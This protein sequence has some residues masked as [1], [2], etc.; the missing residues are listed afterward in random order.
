MKMENPV[1]ERFPKWQVEIG[2]LYPSDPNFREMCD[3]YH[4]VV[5]AL[6]HWQA[7]ATG[8]APEEHACTSPAAQNN[9]A[10]IA[11]EYRVCLQELDDEIRTYLEDRLG[12]Y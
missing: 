5:L 8:Q 4:I 12:P 1:Y 7:L 9:A 6:A 2:R 3:D 10:A 11:E